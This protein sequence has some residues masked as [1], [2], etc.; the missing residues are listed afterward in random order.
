M[1]TP[2]HVD[3][4]H[5]N[6]ANEHVQDKV[7]L[8]RECEVHHHFE[9]RHREPE[10]LEVVGP[11]CTAAEN[12]RIVRL[13]GL[14]EINTASGHGF[15]RARDLPILEEQDHCLWQRPFLLQAM[16][17]IDWNRIWPIKACQL[18][19]VEGLF[20]DVKENRSRRR[21]KPSFQSHPQIRCFIEQALDA[22]ARADITLSSTTNRCEPHSFAGAPSAALRLLQHFPQRDCTTEATTVAEV[23]N[24]WHAHIWLGSKVGA[25]FCELELILAK[26][27]WVLHVVCQN[28][29]IWKP[30]QESFG[31]GALQAG[32]VRE[33]FQRHV[34]WQLN[35]Q[36]VLHHHA[37]HLAGP[38]Y[39]TPWTDVLNDGT[40]QE[41]IRVRQKVSVH[42]LHFHAPLAIP[43]R[44]QHESE[45]ASSYQAVAAK[46]VLLECIRHALFEATPLLC[47]LYDLIPPSVIC[48]ASCQ[49]NVA[50]TGI[51]EGRIHRF[52]DDELDS[53]ILAVAGSRT[54]MA[55]IKGDQK[56]TTRRG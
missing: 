56:H 52:V 3:H 44:K 46:R 51:I 32:I 21:L 35:R 41:H 28:A 11:L 39:R 19:S 18:I 26:G 31:D 17:Q 50:I 4:P 29:L 20:R 27:H 48:L 25:F 43:E 40:V 45:R 38:L 53:P 12:V 6:E 9:M 34:H 36:T 8:Q 55:Q 15:L 2:Q 54:Q 42:D 23:G 13:L 16:H 37:K 49:K 14:C 5:G 10:H 7:K 30:I 22:R 24:V 33:T 1:I 47:N